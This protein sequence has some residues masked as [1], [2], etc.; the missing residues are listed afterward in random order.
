MEE[1]KKSYEISFLL[2]GPEVEKEL[3]G[4]LSQQGAEMIYQKPP[5]ETRL[6]YPIKKN[7]SAQFGFYHFKLSPENVTKVKE[8]LALN[9]KVLRFLIINPPVKL[10]PSGVQRYEKKPAAA[11]PMLSNAVLEEKL[12]EILK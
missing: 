6:A 7:L 9:E 11:A 10:A 1:G 5:T 8:A 2:T 3:A 12:E 4:V